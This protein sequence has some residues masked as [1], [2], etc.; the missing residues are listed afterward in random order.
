[1]TLTPLVRRFT[2]AALCLMLATAPL[3]AQ[4]AATQDRAAT[5]NPAPAQGQRRAAEQRPAGEGLPRL[6]PD[7][8]TRHK[9]D[10]PGRSL[11]FSATAGTIRLFDATSGAPQAD[12]AFIAYAKE[13]AEIRNRPVTFVFNGGPGYASGWLHLG[14]LG[15][16]RL[17]MAGDAARP[18]ATPALEPNAETWLDFTDLVFLDPAGTG[19]S[20]ILGGDEVRKSLWSTRGDITS[21]AV[22]IRRW[23]QA[24]GRELSPKFILGES[25]GGFRAPKIAHVLQTDQGVGVNGLVLLSPVLDFARFDA[26]GSV[27]SHVA[28]LPS[29]VATARE[30]KGPISRESLRDV[31]AYASGAFLSD[32][33]KGVNDP[34]A[35]DRISRRVAEM[36]GLDYA[37]VRRLGGRMPA[38][39]FAREINQPEARVSSMYDGDVTGLDP[40]PFSPRN[41][42]EDQLRLGL[43]A[44]I[45]Q[46]MVDLYRTRLNWVVEN[47]RYQFQNEQAGRQW[48]RGEH[49]EAIG[50]LRN[51]MALDPKLG[52]LVAHGLTDMVTPW[53][54]TRMV[55]DQIYLTGSSERLRFE[56]YA[57]GHM[58]YIRDE[59]RRVFR[60]D[61]ERLVGRR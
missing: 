22:T 18:S 32:L 17:N 14:A 35:L 1:M 57:G 49:A 47:G 41:T 26:S 44:P 36:T 61:G 34:Q 20:R 4:E 16:W 46:A 12:M 39:L 54:E 53:F 45:T 10:L 24:N 50:D 40:N 42:A 48:D 27:L 19:Y 60:A 8:T 3:Q 2:C 7:A 13:G 51:A 9:L 6:P 21:L 31:E 29:F 15:P 56:T 23:V 59:A 37:F 52:V 25:Y 30:R 11:D 5:Q 58:F 28:R 55:L 43:H 38:E 33:M